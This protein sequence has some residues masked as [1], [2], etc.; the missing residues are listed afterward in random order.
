M[1]AHAV[2]TCGSRRFGGLASDSRKHQIVSVLF[3]TGAAVH[4]AIKLARRCEN[5]DKLIVTVLPSFGERYL[6][7]VLFSN[8]WCVA[9]ATCCC[10]CRDGLMTDTAGSGTARYSGLVSVRLGPQLW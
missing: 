3:C 5:R 7:T 2:Q 10:C 4:A 9:G 1:A 8:L 6:S